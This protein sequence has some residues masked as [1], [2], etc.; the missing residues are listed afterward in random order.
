MK[1]QKEELKETGQDKYNH[2]KIDQ[3]TITSNSAG[4]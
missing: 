4:K 1:S 3:F 2:Q